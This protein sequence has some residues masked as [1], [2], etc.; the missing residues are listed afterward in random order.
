MYSY[1]PKSNNKNDPET[2]GKIIAQIAIIPEKNRTIKEWFAAIGFKL[3]NMYVKTAPIMANRIF[4][5]LISFN[6]L[7]RITAEAMIKPKKNE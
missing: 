1:C 6:F 7:N 2:P 3:T 5:K 4:F